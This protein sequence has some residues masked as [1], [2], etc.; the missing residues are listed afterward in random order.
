MED[1][2]RVSEGKEWDA[3]KRRNWLTKEA[4][5][6][7]LKIK[8]SV[9]IDLLLFL[10]LYTEHA[11]MCTF[12]FEQDTITIGSFLHACFSEVFFSVPN[13]H[14]LYV[15]NLPDFAQGYLD[16]NDLSVSI[17]AVKFHVNLLKYWDGQ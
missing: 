1:L 15:H 14:G 3:T 2:D 6:K 16:F 8:P 4:N 13:N 11:R 7:S 9:C 10:L 5:R 12:L 17:P